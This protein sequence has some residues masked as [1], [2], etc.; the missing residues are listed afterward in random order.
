[1]S[2]KEIRNTATYSFEITVEA[3]DID[4]L[5][6]VNNNVYLKWINR[7]ATKHW[8]QLSNDKIDAQYVW[9]AL[10]HEIDYLKPAFLNDVLTVKTWVGETGGV[11]S[12]RYVEIYNS[13][14]LLSKGKTVWVLVD[15]KTMRPKRIQDDILNIL[16][17]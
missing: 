1:M 15:A 2:D 5:N 13:E 4:E 3:A 10:R 7:A 12:V 16:K 14:T 17:P 6:H 8:Q 9:V 11:K